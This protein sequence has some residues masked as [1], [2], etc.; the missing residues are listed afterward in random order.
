MCRATLLECGWWGSSFWRSSPSTSSTS[1]GISSLSKYTDWLPFMAPTSFTRVG[2]E[3]L[4][5]LFRYVFTVITKQQGPQSAATV[6]LINSR[7][8]RPACS[9]LPKPRLPRVVGEDANIES[10]LKSGADVSRT[11]TN[12]RLR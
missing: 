2:I 8:S 6:G 9:R 11:S 3:F 7:K 5:Y 4:G 12:T 1:V 10:R